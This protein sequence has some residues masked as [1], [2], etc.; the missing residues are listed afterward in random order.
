VQS[1]RS[2]VSSCVGVIAVILILYGGSRPRRDACALVA[3][4]VR[5]VLDG[6]RRHPPTRSTPR[7]STRRRSGISLG[8]PP[9]TTSCGARRAGQ[10]RL[11]RAGGPTRRAP[12]T[13]ST[14]RGCL[15]RKMCRSRLLVTL[16]PYRQ[17][18]VAGQR[19]TGD[20][21]ITNPGGWGAPLT[22]GPGFR[23]KLS[24]VDVAED[25]TVFPHQHRQERPQSRPKSRAEIGGRRQGQVKRTRSMV[26][27]AFRVVFRPPQAQKIACDPVDCRQLIAWER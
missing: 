10:D 26:G 22:A 21:T 7:A 15:R 24:N 9:R 13:S 27:T 3:R 16:A 20:Q 5:C 12:T 25:S 19:H 14:W 8:K 4:L 11:D 2:Y 23:G 1:D 6:P 18:P 17:D